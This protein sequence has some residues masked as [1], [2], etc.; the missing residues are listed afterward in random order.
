MN[1]SHGQLLESLLIC[2]CELSILEVSN[3]NRID[4]PGRFMLKG[5]RDEGMTGAFANSS[6]KGAIPKNK[7]II[8]LLSHSDPQLLR[9]DVSGATVGDVFGRVSSQIC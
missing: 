2:R 7:V 8:M 6:C 4:A 5:A 9:N 1:S 3:K